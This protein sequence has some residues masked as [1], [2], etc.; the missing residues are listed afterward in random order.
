MYIKK[1]VVLSA[2]TGSEK[3]ILNIEKTGKG[4]AGNIKLYNFH[5]EPHGILTLGILPQSGNVIKAG[6]S[7]KGVMNFGFES[8]EEIDLNS[9]TCALI[10]IESGKALPLLAGTYYDN[11]TKTLEERLAEASEIV[12][13][14]PDYEKAE[15]SL[16]ENNI[17]FENQAEIEK[18]IDN[19]FEKIKQEEKCRNNNTC[20]N[21]PY[22]DAF[23]EDMQNLKN[24]ENTEISET[25]MNNSEPISKPENE[26][27]LSGDNSKN[28]NRIVFLDPPASDIKNS[29]HDEY[30]ENTFEAASENKNFVLYENENFKNENDLKQ[31]NKPEETEEKFFFEQIH[32]EIEQLFKTYPRHEILENLIPG[33]RWVKVMIDE[34]DE[35]YVVGIIENDGE[36]KY[37]CYGIP[38]VFSA[39]PPKQLENYAQWMPLNAEMPEN[40]GYWMTYQEAKTGKS[41]KIVI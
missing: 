38:G 2:K 12:I 30:C 23:Y 27:N 39:K 11:K 3:A 26:N 35:H 16:N 32:D 9:F 7:K 18:E 5:D 24:E 14:K 31:E 19:E 41:I 40:E 33:S 29:I 1:T 20:P 17:Y 36:L 8:P 13:E 10:K 4:F 34:N 28:E 37:I 25:E 15:K 21:C 6:L 22:R